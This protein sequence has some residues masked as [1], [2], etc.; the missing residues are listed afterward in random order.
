MVND[1]GFASGFECGNCDAESSSS[2][3]VILCRTLYDGLAVDD[4]EISPALPFE[5]KLD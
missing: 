5:G 2:A 1:S 3:R 4:G